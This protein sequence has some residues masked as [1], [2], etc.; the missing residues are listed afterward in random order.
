MSKLVKVSQTFTH[1]LLC[2]F[3]AVVLG[4]LEFVYVL[5]IANEI[6]NH[7]ICFAHDINNVDYYGDDRNTTIKYFKIN[8]VYIIA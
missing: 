6:S 2:E 3:A 7:G 4:K 8:N 5:F 1:V